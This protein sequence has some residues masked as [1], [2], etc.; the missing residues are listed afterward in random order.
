M[1]TGGVV[2]SDNFLQLHDLVGDSRTRELSTVTA[3]YNVGCFLGAIAAFWMG[4]KFGRKNTILIGTVIMAIG[5]ALQA[6]SFSLAHMFVGR[7]IAG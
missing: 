4:D 1:K 7:T 5:A 2:I 6:S 3:I